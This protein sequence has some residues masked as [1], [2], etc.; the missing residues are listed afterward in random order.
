MTCPSWDRLVAHRYEGPEA[1]EPPGWHEALEHLDA[2]GR[3]R[4]RA[5][6]ADP[7]LAFRRLPE[8]RLDPGAV[9]ALRAGVHALRRARRVAEAPSPAGPARSPRSS[10]SVGNGPSGARRARAAGRVAAAVILA[11]TLLSVRPDTI[12]TLGTATAAAGPEEDLP[13]GATR[14]NEAVAAVDHFDRP[15]ASIYHLGDDELDFV[16]VVDPELDV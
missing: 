8:P 2:C 9:D 12:T 4:E 11:T 15:N 3:C 5:F 7:T 13:S 1:P 14:W 6:A 10:R 16:M